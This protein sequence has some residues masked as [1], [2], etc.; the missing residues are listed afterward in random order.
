MKI[1]HKESGLVYEVYGVSR[2][3]EVAP[4]YYMSTTHTWFLIWEAAPVGYVSFW[5]WVNGNDYEPYKD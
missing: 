3:V 5:K 4:I 2:E 1:K